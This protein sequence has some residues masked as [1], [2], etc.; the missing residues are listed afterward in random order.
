MITTAQALTEITT[1]LKLAGIE[2]PRREA[3]L[4]LAFALGTNT[5][6]LLTQTK[7]DPQA[8]AS[9]LVRRVAREPLAYITGHR[10]FWGLDFLTSPATLIPR[11][12]T[13]TLVEAVLE[14]GP[15]PQNIL[16][17]GT[18][19][20]CLLL[21]CLHEY[22]TAFGV[23]VDLRPEAADLARRNAEHLGLAT[24]AAFLAGSWADALHYQFD[25]ILSNPPYIESA[26]IPRLMPEVSAHEPTTALDGGS[27]GLAAY[28]A[29]IDD[30]SRIL[31]PNGLA[32]LELGAGQAKSVVELA[33]H[34]GFKTDL[35]RD[36]SGTDRAITLKFCK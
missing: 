3:R 31:T 25:V 21:A 30:L 12:D 4:L 1:R 26:D 16:D 5:T 23:G 7:V 22:K 8:Y 27:D 9:A 11:P 29:I 17:L 28:K 19:T 13:E 24:R 10:E 20:G 15:I 14:F 34:A 32:V 33:R 6:G 2:E 35:R 36:L 18:G